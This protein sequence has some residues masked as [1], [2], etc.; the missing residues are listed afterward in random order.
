MCQIE[1]YWQT[2]KGDNKLRVTDGTGISLKTV[3]VQLKS[4]VDGQNPCWK[5]LYHARLL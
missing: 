4:A 5:Y 2:R 3:I 1:I